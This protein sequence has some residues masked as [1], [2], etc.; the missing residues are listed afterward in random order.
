MSSLSTTIKSFNLDEIRKILGSLSSEDSLK[1]LIA[2]KY[3]IIKSTDTIKDL[4]LTQKRYYV[5]LNKLIKVGL[6][7]KGEK[8]Y[9]LTSLGKACYDL[10]QLF[11]T[12]LINRERLDLA[13]RLRK[14]KS[15]SIEETKR[16]LQALTSN[17]ILGYLGVSDIIRPIKMIDNF[18]DVVLELV[19]G[20]NETKESIYLASSYCESRIIEAVLRALKRNVKFSLICGKDNF[21]KKLQLL[22]LLFSPQMA[23]DFIDLVS[24]EKVRVKHFDIPYS[25]C[26]LDGKMA[27]IELPKSSHNTFY[28]GF[29]IQ[30]ETLC[31]KLIKTFEDFYDKG[32]E[33][34]SI[35]YLKKFRII[36]NVIEN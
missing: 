35:A 27:M 32:K 13:D 4:G 20:I 15:I 10:G 24:S 19:A 1:I 7:E 23:K 14:S 28:V 25:F 26:V 16:I 8:N 29:I 6:I 17:G 12:T 11:N 3:G 22:Q 31:E 33:D 30:N 2:A 21:S 18:E 9:Q 34:S 36:A 5:R